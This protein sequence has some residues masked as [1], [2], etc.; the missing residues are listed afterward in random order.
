MLSAKNG[1]IYVTE[2]TASIEK[3][4]FASGEFRD[5][6]HATL[7][8]NYFTEEFGNEWMVK[9]STIMQKLLHQ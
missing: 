3:A 5:A 2:I 7:T 6:H 9:L 1:G 4:K 8:N